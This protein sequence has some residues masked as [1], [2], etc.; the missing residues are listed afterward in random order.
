MLFEVNLVV[1]HNQGNA[2]NALLIRLKI[3]MKLIERANVLLTLFFH[4]ISDKYYAIDAAQHQLAGG[5]IFYL[6]RHRIELNLNVIPLDLSHI[7]RQEIK[8]QR[9]VAM[10]FQTH[11]LRG[12][13]F[14]VRSVD[15]LKIGGLAAPPRTVINDLY[16][17]YLVFQIDKAQR[18]TP[19]KK[20]L[21]RVTQHASPRSQL[22]ASESPRSLLPFP[23]FTDFFYNID[24]IQTKETERD[25]SPE[26]RDEEQLIIDFAEMDV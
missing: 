2:K 19:R 21:Q 22:R 15:I 20:S 14:S 26:H 16:L 25:I 24:D 6:P 17:Y 10:G 11:H 5:I 18:Y 23:H 9:S 7:E 13:L 4:G 8:E 1:L 3:F 12:N